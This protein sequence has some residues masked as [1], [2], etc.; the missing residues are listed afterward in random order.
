VSDTNLAEETPAGRKPL[1]GDLTQGPILRT[2]ILFSVPTLF[3]NMLQTL[4]GTINTIWVGQ[5]L[6]EGALAATANANMIIFLAFAAVFGFGM[7]TTVKVGQYFGARDVDA[8]RRTFGTGVG[9][10]TGIAVI[11]AALG[12]IFASPLLHLLATPPAIHDD[13]LAYLRVSF[14]S[15][16]FSTVGMMVSMGLRGTGDAKTPLYSMILTT[17]AEIILNPVLI[18]GLGPF[19]RLGIAGSAMTLALSSLLGAAVMIS[20]S[21]WRD[22]P[23]RLKGREIAYLLPFNREL[24]YVLVKGLP[25]GAQMLVTSSASLIMVG[26]VNREGMMTT[27]AY[28]AVLQIWNYIQMPAFA[29]SMAVSAMVAQNIGASQHHRVSAITVAG[30]LTNSVITIGLTALLLTFDAPLLGLF[31]GEGSPAI[32]IAER[33]QLLATWSWI[34]SGVMMILS[35]T[36]RSYGVVLLPLIIMGISLY[37]ARLGFYEVMHP[38]LG[39]DALWWAYPFGSAVA[40]VLTWLV[41]IRP[42][43]RTDQLRA[44][45][46][47]VAAE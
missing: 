30:V 18:L 14:L 47:A 45:P 7:A 24:E 23:L 29:I 36:L 44:T 2:L 15:M 31:L 28:G 20:W 35:G 43:W 10:C 1:H 16:P 4:G 37:P 27:A 42:G 13:A 41:Y 3:S 21:Y 17:S 40:L 22:L 6:G 39:A 19:P 34:I 38:A 9:F 25:M 46:A 11:G 33:I 32:P 5:L 12:W 26:L 8:A